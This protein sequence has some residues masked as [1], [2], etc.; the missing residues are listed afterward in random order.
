MGLTSDL[1]ASLTDPGLLKKHTT[2]KSYSAAG[3]VYPSIRTFYHPHPHADKLPST[4]NTL[5]L[6]VFI[7]GLG[8]SSAQFAPLLTSLVQAAPCLAIDLPGCGLSEFEPRN[9]EAYRPEALAQLIAEAIQKHRDAEHG[10]NVILI[11]HSMGCSLA[12]LLASAS[13]PLS[14]DVMNHVSGFVALCPRAEPP[15]IGLLQKLALNYMPLSLFE[16]FR[17][18]DRR[19]GVES[20]SV[21]RYTGPDADGETKRLQ[22]RFNEQ[23]DSE[24]F[25]TMAASLVAH[26]E[27]GKVEGGLPGEKVWAGLSVP[28]FLM[29]GESDHVCPPQNIETIAGWLG[30]HTKTTSIV[31]GSDG[32]M[33]PAAAGEMPHEGE[34]AQDT[35]PPSH[36]DSAIESKP[37]EGIVSETHQ[38]QATDSASTAKKHKFVLKTSVLPAPASHALPYQSTSV[39]IVSGLLHSFL[40]THV[41]H[42]LS[43][44]WQL[45]HLTT[46]GKWDVKNL[47]KWQG[48]A[49]VSAPIANIFRGM[50]TLREVDET[51]TPH[52]FVEQW[53]YKKGVPRGIRMVIDISHESPVYDPKGLEAGGIEYHKFPT[54][55]KLPPSVEEVRAYVTLVDA[56]R[57][58]IADE[59]EEVQR[60]GKDLKNIGEATIGTHCHYGYNRTGFFIASYLVEKLGYKVQDAI[61]E[62]AEKRAPGIRHEHFVNELFVRYS[63]LKR[64]GT[65]SA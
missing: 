39:R 46:E 32:G 62:F 44:G 9:P 28:V 7:H 34:V 21:A 26:E 33:L 17:A 1:D 3:F 6:F 53:S 63:G 41:D 64:R 14:H 57:K 59:A 22:L 11:G 12:A 27:N 29:A 13:S 36:G 19:G 35:T 24:V 48:V 8:G 15:T 52:V 56:L 54:V 16:L 45:Q 2:T 23:S 40:A 61:D 31:A 47:Q 37:A 30:H 10:Q 20:P 65:I 25:M 42:R 51:H 58:Q 60:E 43:L 55:S 38:S 5:P 49:P 4:P 50:K 18:Y